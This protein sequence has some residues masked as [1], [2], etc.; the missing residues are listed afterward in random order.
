MTRQFAIRG[1][2]IQLDQLLK[3]LGLTDSGGAAHAAVQAG[4][5]WVD[6]QVER[7]KRAK[8]RPGQQIR[9]AGETVVLVAEGKG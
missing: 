5:V 1:D 4:Q 8:L 3:T 7:R 9:F 2:Y 6:G